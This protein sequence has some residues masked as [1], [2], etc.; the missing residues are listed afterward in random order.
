MREV[1]SLLPGVRIRRTRKSDVSGLVSLFSVTDIS[2]EGIPR[3]QIF[4]IHKVESLIHTIET[5]ILCLTALSTVRDG[6]VLG[7]IALGDY[8][9]GAK[10][11]YQWPSLMQSE[12]YKNPLLAQYVPFNTLWLWGL[13]APPMNSLITGV[14]KSEDA[15]LHEQEASMKQFTYT[16]YR[17]AQELLTIALGTLPNIKY[18]LALMPTGVPFPLIEEVAQPIPA[19]EEKVKEQDGSAPFTPSSPPP[20]PPRFE[21]D[22][23]GIERTSFIP[24]L[25]LRLGRI[26]DYDDFVPLLVRNRGVLTAVPADFFLEEQL[27]EQDAVHK[28]VIAENSV[29][30]QVVGLACLR[31]LDEY[32]ESLTKRY[33]TDIYGKLRPLGM[34]EKVVKAQSNCSDKIGST[35]MIDFLYFNPDYDKSVGDFLPFM[36]QQFPMCEYASIILPHDIEEPPFLSNFVYMPIHHY[37]PHNF[38]GEAIPV[39]EGLWVSCRYSLEPL[40]VKPVEKSEERAAIDQFLNEPMYELSS[41]LTTQIRADI[42]MVNEK[43]EDGAASQTS[44]QYHTEGFSLLWEK[45]LVGVATARRLTIRDM[46]ALRHNY[47]M[48]NYLYFYARKH[49]NYEATDITLSAER[50]KEKFFSSELPGLIIR[51]T[52][53][54]PQF[55]NALSFFI[56]EILRHTGVELALVLGTLEEP[57]FRPLITELL[58]VPPRRAMEGP[59]EEFPLE[60]EDGVGSWTANSRGSS[61]ISPSKATYGGGRDTVRLGKR[62]EY[63]NCEPGALGALYLTSRRALGDKKK[64]VNTRVTV[65]GGGTT[66]LAFLHRLLSIPYIHFTNLTLISTDGLPFH[67]NQ[68]SLIWFV[69][70]MELT[71]REHLLLMIGRPMRVISGTLIDLDKINKCIAVDNRSFEPY[72]YLILSCGRQYISP[73]SVRALQQQE[74]RSFRAGMLPMT[75]EA[76][77]YELQ[78]TLQEIDANPNNTDNIIV[79]GSNLDTFSAVTAIIQSGF[80]SQRIVMCSP[81]MDNPFVDEE[82]YVSITT[83]L[84]SVG[85]SVMR[86]FDVSRLEYDDEDHL[87]TVMLA[88]VAESG[89]AGSVELRCCLMICMEDKDIDPNILSTLNKRSIV[90]DGRVIV[91]NNYRTTDPFVFAAGPVAMFTRRYGATQSFDDFKARDI[92]YHLAEVLLGFLGFDEFFQ[93]KYHSGNEFSLGIEED[94]VTT[95]LY[96]KLLEE[97]GSK[98]ASKLSNAADGRTAIDK[99]KV[100]NALHHLP[101]Y[102]TPLAHRVR[103][104]C[105]FQ[106]FCTHCTNFNIRACEKLDCSNIDFNSFFNFSH[107][108]HNDGD[109]EGEESLQEQNY[110]AI[111]VNKEQRIID[112]VTFFGNGSPEV[113]NYYTLIGYPETVLNL[114]FR[115]EEAKELA[116]KRNQQT[117]PGT[118]HLTAGVLNGKL[119]LMEYLRLPHLQTVFYDRFV[120]FFSELREKLKAEKEAITMRELILSEHLSD[121]FLTPEEISEYQ[122]AL[123]K[124]KNNFHH[125]VQFELIRFLHENKDFRPQNMYLPSIQN[126]MARKMPVLKD[127]RITASK[128]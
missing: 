112:A 45:E 86:G 75:G 93:P 7:F 77:V 62:S 61:S 50:G 58:P 107:P 67:Q 125:V 23:F 115:Y 71:E 25:S 95:S 39:P 33:I 43:E 99:K 49:K 20:P 60:L 3:R 78:R 42:V 123:A 66:G 81:R 9:R 59:V 12:A 102:S 16:S 30:H 105:G 28:I 84:K 116:K 122:M 31:A 17:L 79:Y 114:V 36:F 38:K 21:G 8:P 34:S 113:Y 19:I 82:C 108:S 101:T 98:L 65:I 109:E 126:Q 74:G 63:A 48:D 24:K 91:E 124:A 118:G 72:D 27:N 11:V 54:K 127:L 104:P 29:T 13:V 117:F 18:I 14:S 5:S 69:D 120:E 44:S 89:S 96:T 85:T 6:L 15:A 80:S 68:Q 26:Q 47:D 51:A 52:Y 111:Y 110:I 92:G 1:E 55:C 32:Q 70:N 128:Q 106:F 88:P 2:D 22:L 40:S 37:Q 46:Y 73:P 64:R 35:F 53:V 87:A 97:N 10:N 56:R 100:L 103:F 121:L 83:L 57:P 94:G 90:F 119:N 76:A 41:H 4:D